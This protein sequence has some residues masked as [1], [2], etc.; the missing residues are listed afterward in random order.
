M[1]YFH[2]S[3]LPVFLSLR[4]DEDIPELNLFSRS[5]TKIANDLKLNLNSKEAKEKINNYVSN[6]GYILSDAE[7]DR[8]KKAKNKLKHN[9][10]E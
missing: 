6:M 4:E 8:L 2:K 3:Y 7:K 5:A 1:N 9:E 10:K